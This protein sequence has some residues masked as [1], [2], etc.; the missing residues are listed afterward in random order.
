M[1]FTLE[2]WRAQA[3]RKLE[4]VGQWLE[5]RRRQDLPYMA[6]GTV[7]GLALWPLVEAAAQS[8]QFWPVVGAMY[9]VAGSVGGNLIANQLEAWKNRADPPTEEEV[10]VWVATEVG[11]SDELRQALDAIL[12]ELGALATAQA[13]LSEADKAWFM[14]ALRQEMAQLGNLERF[15]ATLSGGGA[16]AQGPGATA[17]GE[18]SVFVGGS[19]SGSI[20]TGD[21][22]TFYGGSTPAPLPAVLAPLRD[23]LLRTFNLAELNGLCFDLGIDFESLAGQTRPEKA[24]SLV[25]YCDRHNRMD[26]LLARAWA[27]RPHIDWSEG[28]G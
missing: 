8:G 19:V 15:A 10:V 27:L 14:A 26:E 17:V 3:G 6:Y 5:R 23:Q 2:T 28:K 16:I 11:G 25:A 18:R 7:A 4:Q 12:E 1:T 24:Q 9:G 13:S 20:I 22:V 21:N